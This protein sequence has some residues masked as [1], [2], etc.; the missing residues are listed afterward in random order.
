MTAP[1]STFFLEKPRN[2]IHKGPEFVGSGAKLVRM[3]DL[4][5]FDRVRS[6]W[7]GYQLVE[8]TGKELERSNLLV[9]DLLFCRTSV[10][11]NGVGKCS[12]VTEV[13]EDLTPAS[14][15]IRVRLDKER[16]DPSFFYYFFTSSLG[17]A[18]V[19]TKTRGAAVYTVTGGDIGSVEVPDWP[20]ATQARI[21]Q[22]MARYDDLIENNRRRIQ[23][24]EMMAQAIYREWFVEFRFPGHGDVPLVGSELGPIPEE[25]E[26][27]AFSRMGNF[28]NGFAFTP[29]HWTGEG[30][31][32][33]KIK[34]LKNGITPDTP[35]WPGDGIDDKYL[36]RDG[37]LLFSWSGDLDAYIWAGGEAW[38]NQHLFNV[39]PIP[40]VPKSLVFHALRS[41]MR[42]FRARSQGTTMRHIKRAA[43]SEVRTVLPPPTLR[44]EFDEVV[45]P[46]ERLRV[47]LSK[48]A[49]T[50]RRTREFL[51]PRLVSGEMDLSDLDIDTSGL[52]A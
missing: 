25:W 28:L 47:D 52:M 37:D 48:A 35:R 49:S 18:Q 13:S 31:P 8:L 17:H 3:G 19:L 2:G 40:Q 30:L 26:V 7:P 44:D 33:V 20:L 4:F 9:G 41:H 51:L 14:N 43:L 36:V 5:T 1:F 12:L 50:L 29:N 6:D 34:E 39:T 21:A 45:W 23:I 46:M 38:L 27:T 15:L 24:L 11:P 16:A 10:A 22:T 42:E 32:I